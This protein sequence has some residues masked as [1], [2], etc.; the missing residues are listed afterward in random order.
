[1][2]KCKLP[3]KEDNADGGFGGDRGG[4]GGETG[5]DDFGTA[6][7]LGASTGADA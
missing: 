6:D 4:F 2:V 3:P 7:N 1:M 5:V